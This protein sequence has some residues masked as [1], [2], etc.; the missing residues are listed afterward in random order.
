MKLFCRSFFQGE[1]PLYGRSRDSFLPMANTYRSFT[2]FFE[3]V[4][5][6]TPQNVQAALSKGAN[7]KAQDSLGRTPLILAS[8]NNLNP[9]VITTLLKAA[10]DIN[11]H[12]C[13]CDGSPT[14]LMYAAQYNQNTLSSPG[15]GLAKRGWSPPS[16]TGQAGQKIS[17]VHPISDAIRMHSK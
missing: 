3:L 13:T 9:E 11:A 6:G 16:S 17:V 5:T 4:K 14:A 2:D 12:G 15:N 10:A 1:L 8:Q 7:I